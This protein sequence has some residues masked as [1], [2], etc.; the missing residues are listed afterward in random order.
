MDDSEIKEL[1]PVRMCEHTEIDGIVTVLFKKQEVSL[2]DKLFF[3]KLA[4]KPY[5]IDLDEI[6][7]YLWNQCDGTKRV[8]D[9]IQLGRAAFGSKIE[10]AE[11]RII[12]FFRQMAGTKLLE[13][14]RKTA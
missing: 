2:L 1:F 8:N 7:S 12:K 10:P 14:Y 13:L 3:K 6:G 5:N 9:I 4:E 11:E